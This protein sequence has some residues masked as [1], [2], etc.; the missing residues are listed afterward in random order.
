MSS[1]RGAPYAPPGLQ[2]YAIMSNHRNARMSKVLN[3]SLPLHLQRGGEGG[4]EGSGSTRK[5]RVRN[6]HLCR[7]VAN[8][9][10]DPMDVVAAKSR[11][12]VNR[13]QHDNGNANTFTMT[14]VMMAKRKPTMAIVATLKRLAV[15]LGDVGEG[16]R[17]MLV[18]PRSTAGNRAHA[19]H[20][21]STSLR[22]RENEQ[23]DRSMWAS[24]PR[25]AKKSSN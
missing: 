12:A 13:G 3:R 6:A 14:M 24:H 15:S 22:Y 9:V 4:E 19:A 23:H 7:S 11:T 25:S 1:S 18:R 20:A 21:A 8:C 2:D 16:T 17:Q 10:D 5:S